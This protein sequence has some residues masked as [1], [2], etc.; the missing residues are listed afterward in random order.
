MK[1]GIG[2]ESQDIVSMTDE[3]MRDMLQCSALV[4]MPPARV[5]IDE[6]YFTNESSTVVDKRLITNRLRVNL[7]RAAKGR[8][9]FV[10]RHN[11]AVEMAE[12][13]RELKR[14]GVVDGGTTGMT[15]GT[16]GGD[17]RLNGSINSLFR[18]SNRSGK[19]SKYHQVTFEMVHLE[20]L[21]I[22]W[23]GMFE[24]QKT[25]QDDDVYR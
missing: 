23:A 13:E 10:A 14:T 9:T 17:F 18:T 3:M 5:I 15:A 12:N 2:I 25:G 6:S 4:R 21:Q 16:L 8:L 24:F 22:V 1:P 19:K 11:R 20:T 7:N